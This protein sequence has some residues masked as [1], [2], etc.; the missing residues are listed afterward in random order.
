MMLEGVLSKASSSVEQ[1]THASGACCKHWCPLPCCA[2][3]GDTINRLASTPEAH[4]AKL[5]A[6]LTNLPKPC[7]GYTD[8]GARYN[9]F[10]SYH[11]D[12]T[13]QDPFDTGANCD[14]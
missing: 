4:Y 7:A 14:R 9:C 5:P 8:E 12:G 11:G 2:D 13:Y 6:C 1:R 10:C 3:G